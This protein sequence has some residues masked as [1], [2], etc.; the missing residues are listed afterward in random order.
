MA[1][2]LSLMTLLVGVVYVPNLLEY[3]FIPP[4]LSLIYIV[5]VSSFVVVTAK[6]PISLVV[7]FIVI[8]VSESNAAE[9]FV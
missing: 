4:I 9:N 5:I 6:D 3:K 8:I 7:L 2:G 1:I